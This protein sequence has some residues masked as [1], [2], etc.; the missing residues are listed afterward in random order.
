MPRHAT[1]REGLLL[2]AAYEYTG[3]T[4]HDLSEGKQ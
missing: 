4:R 3:M 2:L 1:A